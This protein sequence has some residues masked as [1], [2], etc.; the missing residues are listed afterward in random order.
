MPNLSEDLNKKQEKELAQMLK[1]YGID[2]RYLDLIHEAIIHDWSAN[3]FAM[4]LVRDK[5]FKNQFPGL[6]KRGEVNAFLLGKEDVG[7]S[8]QSL[9]QAISNYKT[10]K[11]SYETVG[12]NFGNASISKAEMSAL[13]GG[14]I[15]VDEFGRRAKAIQDVKKDPELWDYFKAQAAAAGEK[16][17]LED[18]FGV[19]AG[20]A[21][22]KFYDIYEAARIAQSGESL[23]FT[24]EQA[25]AIARAL[26]NFD[27]QGQPT[28]IGDI[29]ELM[30][31]LKANLSDVSPE[32]KA[33]GIDS[34]R[35]ATY[36]ADPTQ[37]TELEGRILQAIASKRSRGAYV[38][39]SQTRKG[40]GG[41]VATYSPEG[42][43]AY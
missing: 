25:A 35:L 6:V 10:L 9:G 16:M 31:K 32:L 17:S 38:A 2:G 7:V 18:Q 43:A 8:L 42:Q 28:G 34:T 14:E 5:R 41:G 37:D 19:A 11:Q 33:A 39:G 24:S 3:R 27:A 4:K 13:I 36:F 1:S 15:S 12:K 21:D 29:G 20:I 40:P 22:Q 23:G 26:P 30:R